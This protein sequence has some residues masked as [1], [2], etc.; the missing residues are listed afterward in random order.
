MTRWEWIVK[1]LSENAKEELPDVYRGWL[2]RNAIQKNI[3]VNVK[4][5]VCNKL[6]WTD[7][8]MIKGLR[9]IQDGE[10]HCARKRI[11]ISKPAL[12][13]VPNFDDE[14][15]PC[16]FVYWYNPNIEI[17]ENVSTYEKVAYKVRRFNLPTFEE[18]QKKKNEVKVN[19][20]AY[21]VEIRP[22][23]WGDG[24]TAYGFAM[25]LSNCNALN[26]YTDKLFSSSF[27]H[28]YEADENELKQWYDSTVAT[29]HDFWE[30]YITGEYLLPEV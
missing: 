16:Y 23:C 26:V 2:F 3:R 24:Y 5:C 19:L 4:D 13:L 20:G 28:G 27:K 29:F 1:V 7:K 12:V 17:S 6:E 18:W 15:N 10:I 9:F 14:K 22:F 21:R 30:Q 25:A 8:Y 11:Y